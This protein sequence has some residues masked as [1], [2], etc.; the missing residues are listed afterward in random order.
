MESMMLDIMYELPE[1]PDGQL[2]TITE[3][4]VKGQASVFE[5]ADSAASATTG[6]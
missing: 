6:T 3:A 4:V 1:R 2:Y 5:S